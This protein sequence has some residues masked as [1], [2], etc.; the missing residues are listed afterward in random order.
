[1][2]E[3]IHKLE[4]ALKKE[5]ERN[6]RSLTFQL[7]EFDLMRMYLKAMRKEVA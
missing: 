5:Y 7:I 1:M 2:R 4:I 3:L 6:G